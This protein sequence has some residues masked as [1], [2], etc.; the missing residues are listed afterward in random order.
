MFSF[1]ES[2]K[3]AAADTQQAVGQVVNDVNRSCGVC[4]LCCLWCIRTPL[5]CGRGA[6]ARGEL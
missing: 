3:A 2:Q 6:E 4:V 1:L 5:T